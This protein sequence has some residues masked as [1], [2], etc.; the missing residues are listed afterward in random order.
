[1]REVPLVSSEIMETGKFH[2]E[3]CGCKVHL[4]LLGEDSNSPV[5][6]FKKSEL[7]AS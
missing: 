5:L 1:M 3:K 2:L 4:C 6:I 7:A